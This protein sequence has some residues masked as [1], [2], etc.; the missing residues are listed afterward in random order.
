MTTLQFSRPTGAR[1]RTVLG[2]VTVEQA[3]RQRA[4]ALAGRARHGFTDV[5]AEIRHAGKQPALP[6][7]EG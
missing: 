4:A 3:E 5:T 6:G 7:M 2:E 1:W